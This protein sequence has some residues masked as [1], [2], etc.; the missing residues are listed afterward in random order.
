MFFFSKKSGEGPALS[1]IRSGKRATVF[2]LGMPKTGT[3]HIQSLSRANE[4][5]LLSEGVLYP[6][7]RKEIGDFAHHSLSGDLA[8]KLA[9]GQSIGDYSALEGRKEHIVLSSEGFSELSNGG[10]KSLAGLHPARDRFGVLYFRDL[11]GF[12]RSF[13]QELVKHGWPESFTTAVYADHL[14]TFAFDPTKLHLGNQLP[15]AQRCVAAFGDRGSIFVAYNNVVDQGDDLFVHFWQQV[16]GIETKSMSTVAPFPNRHVGFDVLETNR[17]LNVALVGVDD[18]PGPWAHRWL[19]DN[20]SEIRNEMPELHRLADYRE[21][22]PVDAGEGIA[23]ETERQLFKQYA[24]QFV[25]AAGAGRI[26][27]RDHRTVLEWAD[28][29]RFCKDHPVVV[30]KMQTLARKCSK[31]ALR[32]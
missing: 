18:S 13:T 32:D 10:M 3:T 15:V 24:G 6:N 14:R 11:A 20:L 27:Q 28:I 8:D 4:A 9:G 23:L 17:L 19:L 7:V 1:R 21:S 16:I 22:A 26:F 25:N 5:K 12:A 31:D 2:H 30:Q 29:E